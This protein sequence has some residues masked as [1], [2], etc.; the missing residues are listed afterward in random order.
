MIHLNVK[1]ELEWE[2]G[3]LDCGQKG[4]DYVGTIDW[5]CVPHI[6]GKQGVHSPL[7]V[8]LMVNDAVIW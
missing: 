6:T 8:S 5:G 7:V 2:L 1:W 3:I 4:S